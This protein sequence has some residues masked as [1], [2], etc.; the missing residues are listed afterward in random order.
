MGSLVKFFHF[1]FRYLKIGSKNVYYIHHAVLIY[2]AVVDA[3]ISGVRIE[4]RLL[5]APPSSSCGSH[6]NACVSRGW[7][8]P[9]GAR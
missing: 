7:G 6:G 4:R 3:R 8:N 1:L 9:W 5:A 2:P